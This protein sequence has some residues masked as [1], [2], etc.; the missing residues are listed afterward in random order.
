[1]RINPASDGYVFRFAT[2]K[3]E[4]LFKDI[5]N[6]YPFNIGCLNK[7]DFIDILTVPENALLKQHKALLE[8]EGIGIE[9]SED[10]KNSNLFTENIP[11]TCSEVKV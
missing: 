2:E 7:E 11:I 4:E 1:M 3:Q 10:A 9:F 5:K 8:T 6:L